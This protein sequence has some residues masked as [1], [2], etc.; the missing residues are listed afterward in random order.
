M[1]SPVH[2]TSSIRGSRELCA[3]LQTVS[4][5]RWPSVVLLFDA[6]AFAGFGVAFLF[7]PAEL[8]AKVDIALQSP[9]AVSE[10]RAFY[11]GLELGVAAYLAAALAGKV[12]RRS[13]LLLAALTLC[14]IGGIRIATIVTAVG[15]H[16]LSIQLAT[17]EMVGGLA[18]IAA[19]RAQ[20]VSPASG[21]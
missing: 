20:P 4:E 8:V 13:A 10:I 12:D 19:Y 9:V 18:S 17:T 5:P 16:G 15:A 1:T 11:G 3:T 7:A 14:F 2:D 6:I 21:D